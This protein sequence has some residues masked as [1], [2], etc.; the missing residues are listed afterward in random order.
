MKEDAVDDDGDEL[1]VRAFGE[2]V[3]KGAAPDSQYKDEAVWHAGNVL[4]VP[5][6]DEYGSA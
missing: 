5:S 2:T 1:K 4:F 3:P 6:E